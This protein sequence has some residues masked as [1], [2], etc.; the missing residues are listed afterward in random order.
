M[1]T[2]ADKELER[3]LFEAGNRL[4]D[5]PSSVD[6]L[7]ALLDQ[8]DKC[9][10]KVEQSPGE[11]MQKALAPSS[12][13]LVSDKLFQHPDVDV[14]VSV[15][16]CISEITRIT[17]PEA[18]YDDEQM[19]EVFQLIVS[20]F[21][22]LS[23][24][25]SRSYEK[26]T[27]ILETVAKVRS[28]V[29]ML[30]LECDELIVEMFQH[31]LNS[32]RDHHPENVFSSM[33]I[34]MSLVIEESEEISME[35]LST[36]LASLRNNEEVLP[37]ARKL[38]EK[39]L[40]S[41]STKLKPYL[42]QA[43]KTLGIS[44]NDYSKVVATIC[45]EIS[46][47]DLKDV[48]DADEHTAGE[49]KMLKAPLDDA[50]Q[51][52]EGMEREAPSVEQGTEAEEPSVE[53]G[54]EAEAPSVEQGTEPE[55]PSVEQEMDT[56]A[57][58]VE[59][60]SPTN[61][62]ASKPV[63]ANGIPQT[64][65]DE[66]LV[67]PDSS[68]KQEA[69]QQK[70]QPKAIDGLTDDGPGSLD[71]E[72]VVSPGH[73]R[74]Q[75]SKR[76]GR[77]PNSLKLAEPSEISQAT[78]EKEAEDFPDHESQNLDISCESSKDPSVDPVLPLE[79]EKVTDVQLSSQ[80]VV[81]G[82]TINASSSPANGS[83]AD[84]SRSRKT[85]R[86]K[87]NEGSVPAEDVLKKASEE[88][89]DTENKE[90]R[91]R[92]TGRSKK[93]EGSVPAEDVPKKA[94]EGASDTENKT[95]RRSGKKLRTGSSKEAEAPLIGD[96]PKKG[97]GTTNESDGKPLKHP[98]KKI[99]AEGIIGEGS[100]PFQTG[101][102]K[103]QA[104]AI[105]EKGSTKDE[106]VASLNSAELLLKESPK[107]NSKRKRTPGKEKEL[108]DVGS[109]EELIG[110]KIKVLWP[111][112]KKY[113]EGV[114]D[115]FDSVKRKHKVVY[116]DGDVEEL[117][118]K[119]E[120]WEIISDLSGSDGEEKA[121]HPTPDASSEM[122]LKKKLK[123]NSDQSTKHGKL[124][125][126][127]KSKSK[128]AGTKSDHKSKDAGKADSKSKKDPKQSDDDDDDDVVGKFKDGTPKGSSKSKKDD[129]ATP[130]TN[131]SKE[132]SSLS[133]KTSKSKYDTAKTDKSR[134]ED[135]KGSFSGKGKTPK[136]GEKSNAN[137]S[138]KVKSGSSKVK[139]GED[140]KDITTD[141][142]KI[143]ESSKGKSTSSSKVSGKRR[144]GA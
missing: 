116:V 111:L 133:L 22:N 112:D 19:K 80:K 110:K 103:R 25:S 105:L 41:S 24:K 115:S 119:K 75:A 97:S 46:G 66:S 67:G 64:G 39:V 93:N 29:V 1:A 134:Q 120:K 113:Y 63:E 77:K 123:A 81:E 136:T 76:K 85:G 50:K 40:E 30:D 16:S 65:E 140:A 87:K 68:E 117:Y 141:T 135:P 58:S 90:S 72:K 37:I 7:L 82:E 43:V 131:K 124:D 32:I 55:V 78:G 86:S 45:E 70:E 14:K 130:K 36:M 125:V 94:S 126:S 42:I 4:A 8:V 3:Q 96:V 98:A 74:E 107:T 114:I 137:G 139:G 138:G 6:E 132:E 128:G 31:F 2:S 53:Q 69:A 51:A 47:D 28:C 106:E 143:V 102:K 89:S 118:L 33:E 52:N 122:P 18:P 129:R 61:D 101:N 57:P 91:S 20:S 54:P 92:K 88:A 10:A 26:R 127:H 104:K 34:I 35:L 23:D 100:T 62:M 121:D 142:A 15:A 108:G 60:S 48:H 49:S 17:A 59:Q 44:Y 38:G 13:A 27:S 21:E 144:R 5:P 56:E 109:G 95:H 11:S 79:N 71:V 12:P 73:N 83:I 84:D 9:L 99:D